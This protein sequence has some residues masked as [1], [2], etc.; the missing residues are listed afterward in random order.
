MH[1]GWE[2]SQCTAQT[3]RSDQAMP[4]PQPQVTSEIVGD[5]PDQADFAGR[6]SSHAW[7]SRC[8]GRDAARGSTGNSGP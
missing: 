3:R 8:R 2:E 5:D 6:L 4:E 1:Q 7:D